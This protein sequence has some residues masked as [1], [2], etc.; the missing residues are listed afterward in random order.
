MGLWFRSAL[1]R[2]YLECWGIILRGI[3]TAPVCPVPVVL[4]L[5]GEIRAKCQLNIA[6]TC[7]TV[8]VVLGGSVVS[9]SCS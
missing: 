6:V 5:S 8:I 3:G 4:A 9:T 2:S 1:G 7:H